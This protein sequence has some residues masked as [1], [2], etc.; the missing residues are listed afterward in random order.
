[1]LPDPFVETELYSFASVFVK[2]L[3]I[4]SVDAHSFSMGGSQTQKRLDI[5]RDSLPLHYFLCSLLPVSEV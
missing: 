2:T 1:M 5:S 4:S 3:E